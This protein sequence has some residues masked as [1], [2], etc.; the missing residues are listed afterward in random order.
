MDSQLEDSVLHAFFEGC[1]QIE[2]VCDGLAE[3]AGYGKLLDMVVDL[4]RASGF[5]HVKDLLKTLDE[6]EAALILPSA[7]VS[8]TAWNKLV[9]GFWTMLLSEQR[10]NLS[11]EELLQV[12]NSIQKNR[13]RFIAHLQWLTSDPQCLRLARQEASLRRPL[14]LHSE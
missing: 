5:A 9:S 11:E 10:H 14:H 12:F 6:A 1:P 3:C 4:Q 7:L 2:E 8:D 13:E